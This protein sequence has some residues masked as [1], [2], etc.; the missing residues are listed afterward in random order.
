[1]KTSLPEE[2]KFLYIFRQFSAIFFLSSMKKRDANS[3][4]LE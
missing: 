2:K 4:I 3:I 1:M